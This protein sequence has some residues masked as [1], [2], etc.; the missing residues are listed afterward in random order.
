[1]QFLNNFDGIVRTK[2][3]TM[4]EKLTNLER[5]VEYCEVAIKSSQDRAKREGRT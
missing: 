2:V 5:K 1:M 3:S 4:N